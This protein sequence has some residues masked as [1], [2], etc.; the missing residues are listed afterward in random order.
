MVRRAKRKKAK[1]Q[2]P[3]VVRRDISLDEARAVVAR[4]EAAGLSEEDCVA[5]WGIVDTLTVVTRELEGKGATIRRLRQLIFGSRTEKTSKVVGRSSGDAGEQ[6]QNDDRTTGGAADDKP[7]ANERA[8][9]KPKKKRKGHG[10]RPAV[11]Y[12]GADREL[13]PHAELTHKACC[14]GCERGKVY[15]QREPAMLVRIRGVAPLAATVVELGRLRCNL[16]GEVFTAQPPPGVGDQK[17]DETAAAMVALMKY[18]CGLPFARLERLEEA[19][20]I[21]L[22]AGTQWQVVSAAADKLAPVLAELQRQAAQG[23]LLHNDDTTMRVL[24]LDKELQEGAAAGKD[25]RTGVFTSGIVATVDGQ[26]IALFFTGRRHAGENLAALLKRRARELGPPIQMCDALSRNTSGDLDTTVANCLAH[27]RRKFVDVAENFPQECQHVL[28]T[29]REVYRHDAETKKAKMSAE[30]R[31]LYHQ[32]HSG[33]LMK[34]L[35]EWFAEQF[36]ERKV[37]PNSVL[38]DAI[39]YMNNHWAKLTLFLRE[40]DAPLDNNIC[41]RALKRVI[42]HRKN[43]LFYKTSKGARVGDTFMSL[44]HTAEM[45]GANVFEYLVALQRHAEQVVDDPAAWMP[46]NY[47]AALA[48]TPAGSQTPG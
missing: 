37:E 9:S 10:R 7:E 13:V 45:C 27:G 2:A 4:A 30:E 14:P 44:I 17:Y 31:L 42:L 5:L 25:E 36:N 26:R 32:Q 11:E 24:D 41:E 48:A 46:W 21:P 16:C 6:K 38:G 18:G 34:G 40:P 33:P 43:A 8:S 12:T 1:R 22:P 23:T 35:Q 19:L 39:T 15:A 3:P 28:E 20:G 47:A 29:L